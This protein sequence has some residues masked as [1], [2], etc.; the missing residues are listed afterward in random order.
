[1]EDER[2]AVLRQAV[3]LGAAFVDVELKAADAFFAGACRCVLDISFL[4]FTSALLFV[5]TLQ[6]LV[7]CKNWRTSLESLV[8][9]YSSHQNACLAGYC[10]QG[11]KGSW[12][13]RFLQAV[14][15]GHMLIL[16]DN[17]MAAVH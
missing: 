4:S 5:Q 1:M 15:M 16:Q 14:N 13:Q 11:F 7:V 10:H 2:L 17:N 6:T 8:F 3:Q 12:L 9:R